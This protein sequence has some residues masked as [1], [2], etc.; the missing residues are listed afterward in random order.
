MSGWS[1]P[2]KKRAAPDA[3][4]TELRSHQPVLLLADSPIPRPSGPLPETDI[5]LVTEDGDT[6][7]ECLEFLTLHAIR[8]HRWGDR[9]YGAI[10]VVITEGVRDNPTISRLVDRSRKEDKP[11]FFLNPTNKHLERDGATFEDDA[12][13]AYI[14]WENQRP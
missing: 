6:M 4:L 1:V 10:C 5:S 12:A 11:L 14:P 8:R 2:T 9:P 7:M 13:H 3:L